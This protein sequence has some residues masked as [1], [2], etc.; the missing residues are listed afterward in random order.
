MSNVVTHKLA[1]KKDASLAQEKEQCAE[2][3]EELLEYYLLIKKQISLVDN[4]C[5]IPHN[6]TDVQVL[7]AF[8]DSK[9]K[10]STSV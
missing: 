8:S 5:Y 3:R 1:Q 6:L 10:T 9:V 4:P 7:T 2:K